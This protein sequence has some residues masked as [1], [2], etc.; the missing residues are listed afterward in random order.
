[1]ENQLK[2]QPNTYETPLRSLMT[3]LA[4]PTLTETI[5]AELP[6]EQQIELVKVQNTLSPQQCYGTHGCINLRLYKVKFERGEELA[7]KMLCAVLSM[8]N[9]S[10]NVTTERMSAASIYEVATIIY[11][12]HPLE[13]VEDLIMCLKMAKM[14]EFG[15]I[16]NR[17]DSMVILDFWGQYMAL[18]QASFEMQYGM[19]KS[20]YGP[21]R[22]EAETLEIIKQRQQQTKEHQ[23]RVELSAKNM[24]I[25][26]LKDVIR[27]G[28]V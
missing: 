23:A 11:N 20:N 7:L 14:G 26:Q 4:K 22:T 18:K 17:V 12:K 27:E 8:F 1:M 15:K 24:E 25:R 3:Y 6:L 5:S 21:Y 9:A 2:H 19:E 28:G 10:L 13:N 16:Y